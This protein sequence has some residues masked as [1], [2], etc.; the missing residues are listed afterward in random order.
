M[1]K[2][3]IIKSFNPGEKGHNSINPLI[4]LSSFGLSTNQ[5]IIKNALSLSASVTQSAVLDDQ[6][7]PTYYNAAGNNLFSR[8]KDLTK[9]AVQ[10][11]AFYDMTYSTRCQMCK[12]LARDIEINFILETICNEAIIPD[13]NGF[14]AQLDLDKLKLFLNKRFKNNN[15]LDADK[16]I[17]DCKIAYNK[18]YAALGWANNN[19][20]WTY[21]KKFLIEGF[22]AFE[23]IMDDNKKN[24]IGIMNI[25]PTTLEPDIQITEDGQELF[26]WYQYKG[27]AN[28]RKIPNSNLIY[29]S[30]ANL[31]DNKYNNIS[32]VEGLTRSFNMLRQLENSHLIWNIQNAQ[33]RMKI[34]VPVN[35]LSPAKA[36]QRIG[37]IINAYTEEISMDDLSGQMLV[38]GEPKFN[39]QK[40]FV[41]E[42]HGGSAVQMEGVKAEGY[43]MNST[44]DLQ[45]F[46]R[47]FILESQ[48]PA[49]RFTLNISSAPSNQPYGDSNITREEY[50]FGRFIERIQTCFK[51]IL[52]KPLLVQICAMH[53]E[54]SYTD[55]LKQGLGIKFNEENVFVLAKKRSVVSDGANA[56]STL[57]GITT[58]DGQPYFSIEWAVKEFLGLSDQDLEMNRQY[59]E[60]EIIRNIE[61]AKL[62]KKHE[63]EVP[64]GQSVDNNS[65]FLNNDNGFGSDMGGFG[66][67]SEMGG[68]LSSGNM[69]DNNDILNG[70]EFGGPD[71][72]SGFGES[73][74][75]EAPT[76][77]TAPNTETPAE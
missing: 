39:F 65:G 24:I 14:I 59:K 11:Y 9:N 27:A 72:G 34:T 37:E 22:L 6:A 35:D 3:F 44:E 70:G 55:Y 47:K 71:T 17:R 21:F 48:V 32:Y 13:E 75:E 61:I 18:I 50:A 26:I 1:G 45:Y 15:G 31:G 20:A 16:L 73:S 29:I 38:N 30:W 28:Q 64:N 33:N 68:G 7:N 40:T 67:G 77:E 52:L 63:G 69:T 66:G 5:S 60:A 49:N 76:P 12:Q 23:I 46:W 8:Y 36:Q 54:F 57:M 56:V 43:N 4:N 2:K 10:S 19:G 42:D 58:S 25:D 74:P 53:P 41:F 51:E 62:K